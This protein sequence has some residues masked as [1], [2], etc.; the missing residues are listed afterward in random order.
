GIVVLGRGDEALAALD[1]P[2]AVVLLD[3]LGAA[4]A[5]VGA[6]V[7]LGEDHGGAPA[8]FDRQLGELLLLLVALLPEDVGE[9]GPRGVHVHGGV[10]AEDHLGHGPHQGAGGAGAAQ[11]GGDR[12]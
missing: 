10:G 3:R 11:L 6:G 4:G 9:A 5:H 12:K 1:V 7:G 2:G 8:A